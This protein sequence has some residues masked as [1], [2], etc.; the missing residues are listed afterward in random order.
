MDPLGFG[1]E[2]FDAIGAWRDRDGK[3]EI[4]SS[5]TLPDGTAFRGPVELKKLLLSQRD[6]FC[7]ALSER[8]LTYALGRGTEEADEPGI[9]DIAE[10]VAKNDYRF[11]SLIL[12][13]VNSPAF[14]SRRMVEMQPK[15][16]SK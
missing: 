2:N 10:T 1:L 8:M 4:D 12:A 7:R 6:A 9:R 16:A 15:T 3:F 13:V 11:S 14:Q 5:G